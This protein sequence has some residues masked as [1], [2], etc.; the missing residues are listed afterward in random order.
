MRDANLSDAHDRGRMQ[1]VAPAT[2]C[3]RSFQ[4]ELRESYVGNE[5]LALSM[6]TAAAADVVFNW[7]TG[8]TEAHQ[9]DKDLSTIT[10]RSADGFSA[11]I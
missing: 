1:T 9:L 7:A 6:L 3:A 11:L 4:D 5:Q 8:K 10:A 2:A